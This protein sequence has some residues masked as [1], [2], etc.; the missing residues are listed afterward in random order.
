MNAG[1]P[2][3]LDR[4]VEVPDHVV[5]RAFEKQTVLLNL[6]TGSYHGLNQVAMRMVEAS[7]EAATPRDAV[8]GLAAAYDQPA[9][10]IEG[11]LERLL[12][13][14]ADRGLIVADAGDGD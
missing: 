11:D 5:S 8:P 4:R 2:S 6:Q 7:A 9:A 14:L 12:Q 1:S 3:I 13:D 10:V